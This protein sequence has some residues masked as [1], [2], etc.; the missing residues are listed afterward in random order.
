MK[1]KLIVSITLLASINNHG[2][3]QPQ[4]EDK[5]K[6]SCLQTIAAMFDVKEQCN[7]NLLEAAYDPDVPEEWRAA[8]RQIAHERSGKNQAQKIN[9]KTS[10]L[11]NKKNKK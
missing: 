8:F 1:K 7:T 6:T 4:K 5:E 10:L 3:Q 2:M 11:S 9:A